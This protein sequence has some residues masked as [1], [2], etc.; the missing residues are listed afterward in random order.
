[1]SL[2][3]ELYCETAELQSAIA[4][5]ANGIESTNNNATILTTIPPH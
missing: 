2:R 1:M 3:T 4:G 5:T